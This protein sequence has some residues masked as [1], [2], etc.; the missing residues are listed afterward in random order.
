MYKLRVQ[1]N[2]SYLAGNLAANLCFLI[3]SSNSLRLNWFHSC[4][5]EFEQWLLLLR[6]EF[7]KL[8]GGWIP[9]LPLT[10]FRNRVVMSLPHTRSPVRGAWVRGM[11]RV[12]CT[13]IW[14][15]TQ[16]SGLYWIANLNCICTRYQRSEISPLRFRIPSKRDLYLFDNYRH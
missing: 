8:S 11:C 2:I 5:S 6:T 10:E 16:C 7:R 12:M 1:S 3:R 15:S 14:F 13:C 9:F 4:S